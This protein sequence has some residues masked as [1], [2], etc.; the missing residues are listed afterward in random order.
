VSNL[1]GNGLVPGDAAAAT[2]AGS[3]GI[4][5]NQ[6]NTYILYSGPFGDLLDACN[7]RLNGPYDAYVKGGNPGSAGS[8]FSCICPANPH[9]LPRI[10]QPGQVDQWIGELQRMLGAHLRYGVGGLNDSTWGVY[11]AGT[12]AA[13]QRF[14]T[15]RHLPANGAVNGKTW[16]A[17]Q[18]AGC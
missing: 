2:T 18:S 15:D 7:D 12:R 1:Q 9:A 5:G 11:T 3:C 4:F 8:F 6:A 14:Q 16:A 10:T 17:I 13:V